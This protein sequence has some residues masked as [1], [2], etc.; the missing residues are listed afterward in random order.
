[1]ECGGCAGGGGTVRW[2]L[3]GFICSMDELMITH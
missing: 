1:M 2:G 3:F